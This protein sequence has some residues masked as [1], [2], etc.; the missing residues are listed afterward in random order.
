MGT[1]VPLIV[2]TLALSMLALATA[3]AWSRRAHARELK[4]LRKSLR[5]MESRLAAAEKA[6][7]EAAHHAEAAGQVLLEKGLADVE[8]LEAARR[9]APEEEPQQPSRGSRTLH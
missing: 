4:A 1:V 2:S 7:D 6:A 8:D 9:R 3:L 5:A